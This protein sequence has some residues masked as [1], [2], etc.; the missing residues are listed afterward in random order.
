MSRSL[1]NIL[2]TGTPGT[3]KTTTAQQ[4]AEATGLKHLQVGTLVK[5]RNLHDGY[6]AKYDT[7]ILNED[8][9]LRKMKDSHVPSFFL[10]FPHFLSNLLYYHLHLDP[11][12]L[13][14]V[15]R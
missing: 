12:I 1:P 14:V 5:D 7:Y 8:K 11:D 15:V 2:I 4:V 3:G 6:D 9:V 10:P 13:S